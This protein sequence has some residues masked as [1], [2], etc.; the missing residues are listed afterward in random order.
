MRK[1]ILLIAALGLFTGFRSFSQI[2][3][4]DCFLQGQWLEVGMNSNGSFGT[5]TSPA[6]YHTHGGF[7]TSTYAATPIL[8]SGGSMDASYDW[9]HDGWTTGTPACMGPYTQPGFPMEG[10]SVQ[11]G[12]TEY[13]NWASPGLCSGTF[14]VPGAHSSYSNIGGDKISIWTG[15]VAG[16]SVRQETRVDTLSSWAVVTTTLRNT[17]GAPL[18]NVFYQRTNDPDN[19]SGWGLGSTTVNRIVHQN[20]DVRHRVQVSAYGSPW[21]PTAGYDSISSYMSL[22]TKDCRARCA[23]LTGLN[24]TSTP[25]TM[26]NNINSGS[27]A[28]GLSA[29]TLGSGNT[30]DRGITLIF[31]VGTIPAFDSTSISYSY[32]YQNAPNNIDSALPDPGISLNGTVQPM[33]AMPNPNY[34]TFQSC[35][36]GLLILPVDLVNAETK[37]WATS[38]WTW[39][40]ATGLS[41]T[42]GAHNTINLTGLG[43]VTTYTII[44][45]DSSVGTPG[46]TSCNVKVFYLTVFTCNGAESNYPCVGDTLWLNAPGDSVGASYR[47]YGPLPSTALIA[48]VQKHYKYPTSM[49]DTGKYMVVKTVAGQSDTAYT[50]ARISALPI[51]T[52]GHN[53][54]NCAPPVNTLNLTCSTDSI[55][56]SWAWI[57]PAGFSAAVQNPSLMF[58]SSKDGDYI[59]TV[60]SVK[61]CTNK[62]TI[63]VKSGP[64]VDFDWVTMPGCPEDKAQFF[65]KSAKNVQVFYWNFQASENSYEV[66]PLHT[67]KA[68]T[69]GLV[70]YTVTLNVTSANGCTSSKTHTIDLRHK[71]TA[72]FTTAPNALGIRDTVCIP[73]QDNGQFVF[74]DGSTATK[75]GATSTLPIVAY[76]WNFGDGVTETAPAPTHQYTAALSYNVSLTVTDSFNCKSTYSKYVHV[77]EVEVDGLVDT[78]V[79][80]VKPLPLHNVVSLVNGDKFTFPGYGYSYAWSGDLTK[81]NSATIKDPEFFGIGDYVFTLT[82]TLN[83]HMCEASHVTTIHS[84][85]PA[86]ISNLTINQGIKYGKSVQLYCDSPWVYRWTPDDGSIDNP[87]V[88]NPVVTPSVTTTYTVYTMDKYGCRDT[89][90]I[91]IKVD[92][93][94]TEHYPTGFTPNGD[95]LNDVFRFNG[96]KY[97]KLLEMRVYN[98]WGQEVFYSNTR[99]IGWD[100]TYKGVPADMGTYYYTVILAR[101]GQPT[102]EVVKGEIVLIR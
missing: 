33:V 47:W 42:T 101:P 73:N 29:V 57:G 83:R 3:A 68:T 56:T 95:G 79:C 5:C 43:P 100:G 66:S 28:G 84:I 40:P 37:T 51:I 44:G 75:E 98:R 1:S 39:A 14:N 34:D 9:G 16:L 58:D 24:P 52:L 63:N 74:V 59:V 99:E 91:T 67:F 81:L 22:A 87:N 25:Q 77:L 49:F 26:W 20:E 19:I 41:S 31:N 65:A 18:T 35:N 94:M 92:S 48:S 15:A 64:S 69:P 70:Q 78:T 97:Q 50:T 55:C 4:G 32:I 23:V 76:E 30:A 88:N 2:V 86:Q 90:S 60:T 8:T 54:P 96:G 46:L 53:Q 17:T 62:D 82:A 38:K 10:W 21:T 12:A 11:V 61:G 13:R 102:N 45:T 93:S 36:S 27:A 71:V 80:L 85:L 89:A 72:S 7:G 6:T